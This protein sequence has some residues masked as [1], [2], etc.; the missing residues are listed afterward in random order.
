MNRREAVA[1]ECLVAGNAQ[2]EVVRLGAA[3]SFWGGFSL[4]DG[5]VCDV[6]H[7]DHGVCLA[8]RVVVMPGGRGSSSSS[9]V[10]LEAARLGI[11]PRAL[12]I[13]ERD[14]IL[15]VGALVAELLYGVSI[16][17]VRA[18]LP[19]SQ[20]FGSGARVIVNAAPGNAF[21]APVPKNSN[22][23]IK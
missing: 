20:G 23:G 8:G 4:E 21:V 12:V 16:P 10:L 9:S 14:P 7:P 15:V 2:G 1:V 6:N 11:H 5:T 19:L 17:V 3:L 13:A 22:S 18:A